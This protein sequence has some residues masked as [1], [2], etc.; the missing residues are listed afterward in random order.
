MLKTD[1]VSQ[2]PRLPRP[3]R[4]VVENLHIAQSVIEPEFG[5]MLEKLYAQVLDSPHARQIFADDKSGAATRA[6]HDAGRMIGHSTAAMRASV[7]SIDAR[8]ESM[9]SILW[10]AVTLA[11]DIDSLNCNMSQASRRRHADSGAEFLVYGPW[12]FDLRRESGKWT[13]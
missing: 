3:C 13:T 1:S 4:K 6:G 5:R 2:R 11:D 10:R 8:V 9:L 12:L 7:S